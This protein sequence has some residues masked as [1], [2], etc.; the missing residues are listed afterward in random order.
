MAHE[1]ITLAGDGGVNSE[2]HG[3]QGK[4]CL[5][6]AAEI[7]EELA[8]LGVITEVAGLQMKDAT[9]AIVNATQQVAEVKVE[10]R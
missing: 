7:A 3:F 2:M 9:E 8:R 10:R 1:I 6:A 4:S 5:K